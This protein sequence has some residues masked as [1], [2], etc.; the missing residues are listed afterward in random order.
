MPLADLLNYIVYGIVAGLVVIEAVLGFRRGFNRQTIKFSTYAS[1]FIISFVIFGKIFPF[2]FSFAKGKTVG[3]MITS[4]GASIPGNIGSI[5]QNVSAEAASYLM[6]VPMAVIILPLCF[7]GCFIGV[8][9]LLWIPGYALCG[10]MGFIKRVNTWYTRL[11]GS[12]MGVLQGAFIAA[13]VLVP[14]AGMVGVASNSVA[15]VKQK[16]P[17]SANSIAISNFYEQG[18]APLESN[19]VLRFVDGKLGF[20]YDSMTNVNVDGEYVDMGEVTTNLYELFVVYGDLG[21]DFDYKNL[22]DE[23]KETFTEIINILTRNKYM[24]T[25][26]AGAMDALFLNIHSTPIVNEMEEPVK[27]FVISIITVYETTTKET[28]YDDLMTTRNIYFIFNDS[29]ALALIGQSENLTEDMFK[30]LLEK[31]SESEDSTVSLI[32]KEFDKNPRFVHVSKNLSDMAMELIIKNSELP[33]ASDADVAETLESV[34]TGI[35]DVIKM[36]KGDFET[37]E[38]YKAAVSENIGNTLLDNGISVTPEQADILAD[39]I[40]ED[41][42]DK[43]DEM[44]DLE[45]AEFLGKYYDTYTSGEFNSDDYPELGGE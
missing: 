22:T 27:S 9:A 15:D 44:T 34:K 5:L 28:V 42:G 12:L 16:H 37:E 36:D 31:S 33:G 11:L 45:F 17:D 40:I 10:T 25:I 14:I 39:K 26:S 19:L 32:C 8:S 38:E 30:A 20:L 35:N 21:A 41:F 1:S 13:V 7:V 29:G 24:S 3:G 43:N 4:F 6:A 2:F 18:I 23:N